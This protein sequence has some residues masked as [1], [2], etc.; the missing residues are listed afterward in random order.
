MKTTTAK[1]PDKAFDTSYLRDLN[2][3]SYGKNNLFPQDIAAF[4]HA[5]PTGDSCLDRFI[6]FVGGKGF[7]NEFSN[8]IINRRGATWDGVLS[9]VADDFSTF[10]GA[11]VN[12]KYNAAGEICELLH[13]PFECCRL[14]ETKDNGRVY[15]IIVAVDWE[16]K[17]T[18]DGQIQ[19]PTKDTVEVYPIFNPDPVVVRSQIDRAGGIDSYK[20]QIYYITKSEI[21]AYPTPIYASA[22]QYLGVDEGV[23]NVLYRNV[24]N[25]FM[26]AGAFVHKKGAVADPNDDTDANS[27]ADALAEFTSDTEACSLL[28]IEIEH[29]ED[30]PEFVNMRG[31]NYDKEFTSSHDIATSTI[32]AKF[33]QE[34]WLCIL[35]GK[36]GFGGTVIEDAYRVYNA[37]TEKYRSV[38]ERA[39]QR[40]Y[41]NWEFSR[42]YGTQE[43]TIIKQSM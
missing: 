8:K 28:D 18:R 25:N 36:V 7:A 22:L 10:G 12:V 1:R 35:N 23:G 39:F 15:H 5:S 43:I 37:E 17:K 34:P 29:S 2:I 14:E 27:S 13:V 20:G 42:L 3:I 41:N 4:I 16:G 26:P 11:A 33:H 38:L 24:K 30:M 19:R 31:A 40:M 9:I 6:S 32:Y 21:V